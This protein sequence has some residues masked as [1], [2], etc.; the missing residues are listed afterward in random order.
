MASSEYKLNSGGTVLETGAYWKA[1][2][3]CKQ[4]YRDRLVVRS[5]Y[6]HTIHLTGDGFVHPERGLYA[7]DDSSN[8]ALSILSRYK[9]GILERC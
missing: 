7:I 5:I 1:A 6:L 3:M 8:A 2:G 4:K 9:S